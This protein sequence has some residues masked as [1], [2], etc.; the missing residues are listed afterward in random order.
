MKLAKRQHT[1]PHD[2][3]MEENGRE[4]WLFA[5]PEPKQTTSIILWGKETKEPAHIINGAGRR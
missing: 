5:A 4:C 3:K 1:L 2:L